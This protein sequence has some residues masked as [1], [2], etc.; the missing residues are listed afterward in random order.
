LLRAIKQAA[1]STITITIPTTIIISIVL[2]YYY[3][4]TLGTSYSD[5]F[6][7]FIAAGVVNVGMF[8]IDVW[9]AWQKLN[10]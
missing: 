3:N 10:E 8:F 4:V 2:S 6:P 1:K 5:M 7:Y 9:L